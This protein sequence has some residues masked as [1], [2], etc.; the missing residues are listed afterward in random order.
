MAVLKWSRCAEISADRYG[1]FCCGKIDPCLS[2]LFKVAF[3]V[4]PRSLQAL[5]TSMRQ[6]YEA[7]SVLARQRRSDNDLIASR[8]HPIIP[9]R[10]VAIDITFMDIQ[11]FRMANSW[12]RSSISF[13]DRELLEIINNL[14]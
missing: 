10:C 14:M 13:I 7:L 5:R 12:N 8:S 6:Q 2:A 4:Q 9:L 11:S 3:G 1:M